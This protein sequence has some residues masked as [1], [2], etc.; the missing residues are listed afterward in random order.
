MQKMFEKIT[1]PTRIYQGVADQIEQAVL[2]GGHIKL[3]PVLMTSFTT[4]FGVMPLLLSRGPG[5]EIQRPLAGVVVGGLIT[6]TLVTL[7]VLP[8][9]FQSIKKKKGKKKGGR[10]RL[11]SVISI[12]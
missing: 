9:V 6:S 8:L 2:E 3:R 1:R 7:V 4:I 10:A 12:T 11:Y 5:A